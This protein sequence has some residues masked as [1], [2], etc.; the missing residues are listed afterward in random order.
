MADK[1]L[2]RGAYLSCTN[3]ILGK[4]ININKTLIILII[5]IEMC[6]CSPYIWR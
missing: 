3:F 5:L 4:G 1:R 6:N 2:E